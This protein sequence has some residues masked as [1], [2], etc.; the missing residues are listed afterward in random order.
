MADPALFA[1]IV[2]HNVPLASFTYLKLGGA[3][4]QL[5]TPRSR[6]ELS[7]FV[8]HCADQHVPLHVLGNGCNLL[9]PDEGVRGAVVRLNATAF[10]TVAVEARIVNAGAGTALS[11]LISQAARHAL[12]GLET[13]VGIL[14][15][16]GGALRCSM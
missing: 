1:D 16:V 6:D 3:A 5:V 10:S 15:T 11:A 8:R 12:T 4:E 2:Q 13:L 14:G 9:I 7:A